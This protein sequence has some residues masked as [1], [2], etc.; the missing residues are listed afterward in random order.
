MINKF[1]VNE[2]MFNNFLYKCAVRWI[3]GDLKRRNSNEMQIILKG[4]YKLYWRENGKNYDETEVMEE[5]EENNSSLHLLKEEE[6]LPF[7]SRVNIIGEPDELVE[8][9]DLEPTGVIKR[10]RE[11]QY[12]KEVMAVKKLQELKKKNIPIRNNS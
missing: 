7:E 4:T 9:V 10:K 12:D 8:E 3:H 6:E 5:K 1:N 2:K 11:S